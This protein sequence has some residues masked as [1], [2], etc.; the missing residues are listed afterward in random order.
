VT[1]AHYDDADAGCRWHSHT[2]PTAVVIS[3]ITLSFG[4]VAGV[5]VPTTNTSHEVVDATMNGAGDESHHLSEYFGSCRSGVCTG[6][7]ASAVDQIRKRCSLPVSGVA[8]SGSTAAILAPSSDSRGSS[9]QLCRLRCEGVNLGFP[10]SNWEIAVSNSMRHPRRAVDN[11]PLDPRCAPS[12]C[13]LQRLQ[14]VV[15]SGTRVLGWRVHRTS[16]PRTR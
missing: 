15:C 13:G 8:C 16:R 10:A 2:P 9:L 14:H 5:L 11:P 12:A 3:A 4:P 6:A 1:V 7:L